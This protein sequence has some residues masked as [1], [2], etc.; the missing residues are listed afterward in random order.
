MSFRI[1]FIFLAVASTLLVSRS[2]GQMDGSH[3]SDM[4]SSVDVSESLGE[5]NDSNTS[6]EASSKKS[7]EILQDSGENAYPKKMDISESSNI[8]KEEHA[9]A[10]KD[11]KKAPAEDIKNT[12]KRCRL[13]QKLKGKCSEKM[14]KGTD[15]SLALD[16]A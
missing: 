5:L 3:I 10:R 2:A 4:H 11:V 12:H 7:A 8:Q 6:G 14:N 9:E 16:D 15:S 1:S 13:S